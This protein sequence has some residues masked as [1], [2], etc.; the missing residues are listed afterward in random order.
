[1]L[2]FEGWVSPR[3]RGRGQIRRELRSQIF[4]RQIDAQLRHAP[5]LIPNVSGR[6]QLLTVSKCAERS[7]CGRG[8]TWTAVTSPTCEAAS[9]PASVAAL[10]AP[11]SPR[12]TTDTNPPPTSL[13][14]II[15]TLAA[16][17]IASAAESAGTY[18]L[19]SIIPIARFAILGAPL[20]VF[21]LL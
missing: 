16:L 11:T 15:S 2:T 17:T 4:D 12:T 1:M 7:G 20:F 9:A 10:T 5:V 19:V 14:A 13:R 3:T 18:P 6:S 8:M 21:R